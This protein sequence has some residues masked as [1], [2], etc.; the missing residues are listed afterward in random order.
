MD[1][2]WRRFG[3]SLAV[4][5]WPKY[6][7]H[8][9][10]RTKSV[11]VV[12]L[13]ALI[14][15]SLV[16]AQAAIVNPRHQ[17]ILNYWTPAAMASAQ[18]MEY[19]FDKGAKV[20]HRVVGP[21]TLAGQTAT[22]AAITPNAFVNN[23]TGISWVDGG[24]VLQATGKVFFSI[25][26]A[27]YVCSGSVVTETDTGRSIVLTAGHCVYDQATRAFVTNFMFY[28]EYDTNPTSTCANTK[29]GCWTAT[30]LVAHNGWTSQ[31]GLNSSSLQYDWGF[32]V[33]TTGGLSGTAQLDATVGSFDLA[34]P[35]F[36][37]GA[38]GFSF[39]YPAAAPYA[40]ADLTYC[41]Q[42]LGEDANMGNVTW[43][44]GSCGMTG[45]SSGGP[46]MSNFSTDRGGLSSVNSYGYTGLIGMYGPKFNTNT[47]DTF[48]AALTA[49]AN[50][51]VGGVNVTPPVA[52]ATVT[53]NATIGS[54]LTADTSATTGT[55]VSFTYRWQRAT[56]VNG[57]Y[58]N[59]TGA[60]AS[61]YVVASADASRF[62]R[63]Q[64]VATNAGGSSTV[65]SAAVGPV[66]AV[67]PV[68]A[69]TITGTAA[70]GSRLTAS[71]TGTTG[72]TPITY[73]Y[74]W[75][76]ALTVN[77]V[78]TNIS[79]ATASTYTPVAGDAGYVIR[80]TVTATNSAGS[81]QA[82]SAPT[83]AV[84]VAPPVAVVT[85]SG[86]A[87]QNR[88]ITAVTTATTGAAPITFTYQWSRS[89]ATNGTYTPIA[90]AT[91]S[92]YLVTAGDVNYYIKVTIVAT[93]SAGS[94]TATSAATARV[95]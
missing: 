38:Q 24:L 85:I 21:Q 43:A 71:T 79:G 25:G 81:N 90:N 83:S 94:S 49:N 6:G 42:T 44:M 51:I 14:A 2:T 69:V 11:L 76:R 28:P 67:A 62:I 41:S 55:G 9:L 59:I 5:V 35:G 10:N 45:G 74:V 78:F 12:A 34:V 95:R 40:G 63:V 58:S 73:S 8:M 48:N 20:A 3:V 36:T 72:S 50:F 15:S 17:A 60:R 19:R 31:P 16:P 57:T 29:W 54:T 80:V 89:T 23:A 27:R 46:W 4:R 86:T 47:T 7:D 30:A 91:G 26:A 87:R 66:G 22:A 37:S 68:A 88:T 84:V 53:G 13:L 93:N 64:V 65:N 61:T 32:A 1:N 39:G 70:V 75:S 18:P 77:D 52:A 82:T 92:T 33:V 56:T